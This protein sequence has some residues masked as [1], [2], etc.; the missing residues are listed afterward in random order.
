LRKGKEGSDELSISYELEK[1]A[2]ENRISLVT[3][4]SVNLVIFE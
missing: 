4:S 3:N 2:L 1:S